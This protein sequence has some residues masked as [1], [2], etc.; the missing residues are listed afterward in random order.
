MCKVPA[1]KLFVPLLHLQW[2]R[3]GRVPH[4]AHIRLLLRADLFVIGQPTPDLEPVL[5]M[6][7]G[8]LSLSLLSLCLE[9]NTFVDLT[10]SQRFTRLGSPERETAVGPSAWLKSS[11]ASP[12]T[13]ALPLHSLQSCSSIPVNMVHCFS[14]PFVCR[15][16]SS[17][18]PFAACFA[19]LWRTTRAG[20]FHGAFPC[21]CPWGILCTGVPVRCTAAV[22]AFRTL[23]GLGAP[24]SAVA[25][26]L[27]TA[28]ALYLC[29]VRIRPCNCTPAPTSFRMPACGLIARAA[30]NILTCQPSTPELFN[31]SARLLSDSA[32]FSLRPA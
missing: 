30:V 31:T 6:T 12:A 25:L 9:V 11:R 4:C 2:W 13:S 28:L 17:H 5:F 3:R 18:C 22:H 24:L 16:C 21:L 10:I 15:K 26:T 32:K 14:C 27:H 7:L 8:A 20:P 23:R 29:A 19:S 1:L